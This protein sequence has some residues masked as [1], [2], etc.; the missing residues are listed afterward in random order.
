L[1]HTD[2]AGSLGGVV[3]A[4]STQRLDPELGALKFAD[5]KLLRRDVVGS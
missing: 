1:R 2:E 3:F 5:L 4:D